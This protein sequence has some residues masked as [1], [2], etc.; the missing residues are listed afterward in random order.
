MA[1]CREAGGHTKLV[2]VPAGAVLAVATN[3]LQSGLVDAQWEDQ[4]VSVFVQD[5]KVRAGL[6]RNAA[7]VT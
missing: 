4:T 7:G 5:L 3:T 6:V 1:V 2:T